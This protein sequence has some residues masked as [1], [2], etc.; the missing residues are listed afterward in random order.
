PDLS[1]SQFNQHST[2]AKFDLT[3]S[4]MET[5]MGLVGRWEYNTDLFDGSTIARMAT[6]FQNLLS[7]IVDNP[8]QVVSE[9]PLLSA[10]ERHQLLVEWNDTASDYPTDKCIH[11]L[12]SEQVEKTPD[13]IAVVFEQQQLTYHQLN[14]RANQLAHHLLSMGVG[15]EVLVGICVERSIQ[16]V[17]GLLGILKAGGAYVP[18]DPNYPRERLSYMLADA[19]V[20]VLLTQQSL[21]ESLPSHTPRMVCFDSDW[22]AIEQHSGENLDVGVHSNNLAYVIYTSG[23]T[24]KP[25]GV[26][27]SHQALANHMCWMGQTFPLTKLDK[28]LQKT[29]FSFDAS[30]WEFYAPLLVGAQLVIAKPEGHQDSDYLIEVINQQKITVLQL[31]PSLLRMLLETRNL[32]ICQYLKR[33]FCGGEPLPVELYCL[34]KQQSQATL[35]NLYGPTEACI[36]THF[37]TCH[38]RISQNTIP[39]GRPIVNTQTYILDPNLQPVPIGVPGELY[40][41]GDGLARGYLNRPELTSEKFIPNPFSNSKSQRL[42]KTGDLVRYLQDGNIEF[43]GRIDNQVKIRGFRIELGEIESVL[44]THPQIQQSVVIATEDIHGNKRLVAYVVSESESLSTNQVR[45]FL[46]Q[47]LPNYMVPSAF[48]TLETL[49]LTPNGKVDRKS[50]PAPDGV[51]T[52]VVEYVAPRTPTEE[53]IAKIFTNVL[54]MPDVGIHDNFFE[55]GGHSLLATQVVSRIQQAFEQK[56]MLQAFFESPTI[57]GIAQSIEVLRKIAQDQSTSISETEQEYEDGLL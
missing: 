26:A 12:F 44:S 30:I 15:P 22:G 2:I 27:I 40:I 18:L 55:I 32:A 3:L 34:F 23:S 9:L 52:S 53:I 33:V 35:H 38:A 48:V 19:G 49:P 16:M 43:I 54:G 4:M 10:E 14:Q 46:K 39:I 7:A 31:V 42:Y 57:A 8:Q 21:L 29:P 5:D 50:L 20:E 36:D 6:H 13:A 45:E 28:V 17:V 41:G 51:F 37:Y 56:L 25:K 47:K 1:L 11:Q 24:G